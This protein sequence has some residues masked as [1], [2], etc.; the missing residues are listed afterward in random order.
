M[1]STI[2]GS[3]ASVENEAKALTECDQYEEEYRRQKKRNKR[4]NNDDNDATDELSL[5]PSEKF[6]TSTYNAILGSLHSELTKR[7]KA[8]KQL[9][10]S[11]SVFKEMPRLTLPALKEKTKSLVSSYP[12]DL[13][14]ALEDEMTQFSALLKTGLASD[15]P[16]KTHYEE[17]LYKL[18]RKNNL[19]STFPN[20]EIALRI[21]LSLMVSN[22]S[23][24]R[25]FS[26]LKRIK[27]ELRTSM[28]QDRLNHLS[29]LSIEHELLREIDEKVI[30]SKFASRKSRNLL[31]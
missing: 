7:Q 9:S 15:I 5:S 12:E 11:F 19:E 22:C 18:I 4:Y 3:F 1:S 27:N 6:G 24:E 10:G 23:G 26:K 25:S 13:E 31:S 29:L 14:D 21:Y 28:H 16:S 17:Q 2:S 8:Y 20:V 30:I